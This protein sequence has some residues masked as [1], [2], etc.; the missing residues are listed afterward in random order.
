QLVAYPGA[1][2]RPLD[3]GASGGELSRLMLGLEVV[4]AG[5]NPVPTFVFDEVDAGI[6]GQAAVEVGRRLAALARTAQ[7]IVVTHLPQVAAFADN[8]LVVRKTSAPEV[9]T[10]VVERVTG[11]ARLEELSRMLAGLPESALGRSH[12]EELLA[13]ATAYKSD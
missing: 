13:V 6:G 11:S 1:A 8:H 7:V 12:A 4:L 5:N 3:K 2:P 10:T 9:T